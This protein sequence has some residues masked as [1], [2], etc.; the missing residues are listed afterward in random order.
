MIASRILK[1]QTTAVCGQSLVEHL[2]PEF[3]EML[4]QLL[5]AVASCTGGRRVYFLHFILFSVVQFNK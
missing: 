2:E 1:R 3:F 4:N 5:K